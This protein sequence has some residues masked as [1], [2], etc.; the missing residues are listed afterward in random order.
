MSLRPK[1][2]IARYLVLPGQSFVTT[3]IG[4]SP[5][6]LRAGVGYSMTTRTGT[7]IKLRH[8]AEVR[9][10]YLN[11]TALIKASQAF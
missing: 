10:G 11:H 2:M 1:Q 4:H 9:S 6:L 3:N 7:E 8:D 5:W